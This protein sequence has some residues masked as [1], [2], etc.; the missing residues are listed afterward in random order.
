MNIKAPTHATYLL[1]A[2]RV[3]ASSTEWVVLE[4]KLHLDKHHQKAVF[5]LE[6]PPHGVD[7]LVST[8][9]IK[10]AAPPGFQGSPLKKLASALVNCFQVLSIITPLVSLSILG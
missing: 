10:H 5:Y 6:G 9:T 7:L 8:V 3:K 1:E 4:G 2:A